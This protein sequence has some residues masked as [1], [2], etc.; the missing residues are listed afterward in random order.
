V[1]NNTNQNINYYK[2]HGCSLRFKG[3]GPKVVNRL[4]YEN[5]LPAD[6]QV[7]ILGKVKPLSQTLKSFTI[8]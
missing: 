1:K 4:E 2:V 7:K 8:A 6:F 3:E 5:L